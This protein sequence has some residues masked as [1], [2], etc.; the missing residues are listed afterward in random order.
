VSLQGW[1]ILADCLGLGGTLMLFYPGWRVSQSMKLI[2]EL[3]SLVNTMRDVGEEA[4]PD[5]GFE[6]RAT[7]R[8]CDEQ[9]SASDSAVNYDPGPELVEILKERAGGWRRFEH[10]LLVS[11]ICCIALSFALNLFFVKI[12]GA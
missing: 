8:A 5:D 3:S 6:A 1:S 10:W 12:A 4:S 9:P 11:G 2:V 7:Q